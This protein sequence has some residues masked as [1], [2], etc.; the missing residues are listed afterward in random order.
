MFFDELGPDNVFVARYTG[1]PQCNGSVKERKRRPIL[2]EYSEIIKRTAG[3]RSGCRDQSV[4]AERS[5]R[6]GDLG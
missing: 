3:V 4:S 2:P 1:P 5:G 6:T